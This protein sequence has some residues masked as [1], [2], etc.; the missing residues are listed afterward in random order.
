MEKEK[1][2]VVGQIAGTS[3]GREREQNTLPT[4]TLPLVRRRFFNDRAQAECFYEI[5]NTAQ[6][7][8]YLP[9]EPGD[10]GGGEG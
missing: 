4:S 9:S 3:R 8:P 5:E 6:S 1:V 2:R 10:G 7:G